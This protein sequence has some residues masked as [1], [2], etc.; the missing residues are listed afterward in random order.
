MKV[1]L[2]PEEFSQIEQIRA[3]EGFCPTGVDL[4]ARVFQVCY[5]DPESARLKNFQ[6]TRDKFVEFIKDSEPRLIGI[7]ACSA[8]H[9][10]SREFARYGHRCKVMSAAS[11]KSFIG[12]DKNDSIDAVA[13]LKGTF[14]PTIR[15]LGHRDL[16][17]QVLLNLFSVREQLIKQSTQGLNALRAV[18]YEHGAVVGRAGVARRDALD[19]ALEILLAKLQAESSRAYASFDCATS[20]LTGALD[21]LTEKLSAIDSRIISIAK[22]STPCC[23]LMTIPSV[24]PLTAAALYAAM[25]N[26]DSSPSSRHFASYLGVAPRNTGTGG[27]VTVLGIRHSGCAFAKRML[28]MCALQYLRR[29]REGRAKSSW[30]ELRL[31]R[32]GCHMKLVCAVANRLARVAHALVRKGED[33]EP[34]KCSLTS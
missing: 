6:L 34:L 33:Y 15:D 2:L 28:F 13:I 17:S 25:G 23:H 27:K 9:F 19:T 4:A 21:M 14:T 31:N 1:K 10:W 11:I 26:P 22:S 32:K 20:A 5:V 3:R 7:E 12:L 24:G 8:V 30:L 18:L 29:D 16:E